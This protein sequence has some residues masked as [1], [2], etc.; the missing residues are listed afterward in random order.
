MAAA[1]LLVTGI[2]MSAKDIYV[3]QLDRPRQPEDAP[4]EHI[5]PVISCSWNEAVEYA[6]AAP[7]PPLPIFP[8]GIAKKAPL[9]QGVLPIQ[10]SLDNGAR[11]QHFGCALDKWL[12][13]SHGILPELHHY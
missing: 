3:R 11:L 13:C 5:G 8:S 10:A 4:P 7:Q 1:C 12:A 9:F 6:D 2:K